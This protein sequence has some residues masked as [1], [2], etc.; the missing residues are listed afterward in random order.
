MIPFDML[1]KHDPDRGLI[2]DCFRACVAS[3]L[4]VDPLFIPH[5]CEADWGKTDDFTWYQDLTKWLAPR[6]LAYLLE[7][8]ISDELYGPRW[9]T[10]LATSW[11]ETYHTIS[12]ESPRKIRHTVVALNGLIVHDPHPDRTGLAEPGDDGWLYGFFIATGK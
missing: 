4:E 3:I 7:L 5:F 1:I 9:F 11:F 10:N 12:G 2:G 8:S 6:K